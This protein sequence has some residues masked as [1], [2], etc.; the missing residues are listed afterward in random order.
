MM[1]SHV[2][3]CTWINSDVPCC[4]VFNVISES[5]TAMYSYVPCVVYKYPFSYIK[6]YTFLSLYIEVHRRIYFRGKVYTGI[7][8]DMRFRSYLYHSIVQVP[9]KSYI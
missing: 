7:Y 6:V 9:L 8:L 1:Y 2:L 5:Y 4:T 3:S